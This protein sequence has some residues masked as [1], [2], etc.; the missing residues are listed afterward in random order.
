MRTQ[1][2]RGETHRDETPSREGA[3]SRRTAPH[4]R[5]ARWSATHPWRAIGTWLLF[6]SIAVALAAT[7]PT[8]QTD[9]QDYRMG[10]SGQA[11]DILDDAGLAAPPTENVLIEAADGGA[12]DRADA[13]SAAT[14]L[15]QRLQEASGVHEVPRAQWSP[16][17]D[18]LLLPVHLDD[19]AEELVDVAAVTD[20]VKAVAAD[21]PDLDVS[22]AGAISVDAGV[23]DRVAEDLSS[24]EVISLP[25]TLGL[26]LLAFGALIAAGVPVLLGMTSVL[27]TMGL[28][29]PISHLFPAEPSVGSMILL[30]GMAVGV[31]Y[32]L[33]YLKREREERAK[34]ATTRDAV[35]IA[36]ATS[37]HAIIVSGIAVMASVAGLYAVGTVTFNSLASGAIVV[38]AVAVLGSLTVLPALLVKL[39]R[40]VDRPRVPLLWRLNRR[41]GRGGISGRILGPVTRRPVIAL[42]IS[43]L[44]VGLLAA[45]ALGLRL[46]NGT[47]ET[48]PQDIPEVATSQRIADAFPAEG[49]SVDIVV[50]SDADRRAAV[51]DAMGDLE[52]AAVDTGDFE[53]AGPDALRVSADGR[54]T[55][56]T[57]GLSYADESDPRNDDAVRHLRD[58]LI[59]DTVDRVADRVV[60][61]G[62]AAESLD[63]ADQQSSRLPWVIGSVL[64][65]TMLMMVLSFRSIGLALVSSVLNLLS[66]GV[67]FGVIRMIFQEGWLSG[68]LDFTSPGYVIDWVPLFILVVLVGL[69]MDYHV[70][71]LS[72]V[73][74]HVRDGVPAREAVRLGVRD[75]AGV[76]TSAAAVMVSV[77]AIFATLSML[78][79]KTMGVGLAV[80]ILVDATLIR[81]VML[82]AI[83]VL[84]GERVWPRRDRRIGEQRRRAVEQHVPQPVDEPV[85]L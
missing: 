32:S 39:G 6:V 23:N 48:L 82:P 54:T 57:L 65:L 43:C 20:A 83:L 28:A 47:L 14:D 17:G 55:V 67:T 42:L 34:G 63:F 52:T 35:E 58:T 84:L 61:G 74:E 77:F 19:D 66:V 18:S 38:V 37:G 78:E 50:G 30:V 5:L 27:A 60:V 79:M 70:F 69:S 71:V 59:P 7:V 12:P 25:V 31:D 8:Q 45:P 72:R 11:A 9:P 21:H 51:A 33:F 24:A 2:R 53:P 40:W 46:H 10:D 80:A 73:R 49:S 68:V 44:A 85:L 15:R 13:R 29:A 22:H 75:T 1:F 3:R 4:L 16:D 81:L 64:A 41:I 76:V 56:L 62:A 26:M 36:A